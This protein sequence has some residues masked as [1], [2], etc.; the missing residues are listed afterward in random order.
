MNNCACV[1]MSGMIVMVS[2]QE[3]V[4]Q[5]LGSAP[6]LQRVPPVGPGRYLDIFK[7]IFSFF[8]WD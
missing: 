3:C 8:R 2:G 7:I 4:S 1:D 5:V 6:G